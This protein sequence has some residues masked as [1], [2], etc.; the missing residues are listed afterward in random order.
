[1]EMVKEILKFKKIFWFK[2]TIH[3]YDLWL[4]LCILAF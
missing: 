1:M 2:T 4:T 3:L